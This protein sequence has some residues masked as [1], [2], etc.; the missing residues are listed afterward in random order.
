MAVQPG[1]GPSSSGSGEPPKAARGDLIEM[2]LGALVALACLYFLL[3]P[4]ASERPI[5]Q[6]IA[7]F[8]FLAAG[9]SRVISYFGKR[10]RR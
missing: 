7:I 1:S 5:W 4:S 10:R 2:I 3:Q 8:L 6:T 9:V